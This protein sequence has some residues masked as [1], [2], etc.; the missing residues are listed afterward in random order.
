ME[1]LRGC[2]TGLPYGCITDVVLEK[3]SQL[4]DVIVL[5]VPDDDVRAQISSRRLREVVLLSHWSRVIRA[6]VVP[7][8]S[9]VESN[10]ETGEGPDQ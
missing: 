10:G 5:T 9:G 4:D 6:L 1:V 8:L 7:R 3:D 2:T